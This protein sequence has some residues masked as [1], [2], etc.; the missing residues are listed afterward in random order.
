VSETGRARL[1]LVITGLIALGIPGLVAT[2]GY[3]AH[4]K[5][6]APGAQV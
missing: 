6:P 1:L 4:T 5:S 3:P 2:S